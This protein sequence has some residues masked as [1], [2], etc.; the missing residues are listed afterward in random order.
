MLIVRLFVG[1]RWGHVTD[2]A[3]MGQS[4]SCS[5]LGFG[6]T[7]PI[8]DGV[9]RIIILL[10]WGHV[11]DTGR[12]HS[13]LIRIVGVTRHRYIEMFWSSFGYPCD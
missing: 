10:F 8:R 12:S 9:A 7:S 11:A 1:W 3:D 2:I 5:S 13:W 6:D 4:R